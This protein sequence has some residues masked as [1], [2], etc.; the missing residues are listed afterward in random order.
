MRNFLRAIVFFTLLLLPASTHHDVG[1]HL[2]VPVRQGNDQAVGQAG[3]LGS[4]DGLCDRG[5]QFDQ[6]F[7]DVLTQWQCV[8]KARYVGHASL[9]SASWLFWENAVRES[10]IIGAPRIFENATLMHG[11][12]LL[13]ALVISPS[14]AIAAP[15]PFAYDEAPSDG[16]MYAMRYQQAKL[17]CSSLPDDL[18]ADYAKAMRLTAENSSEFEKT[19]TKGLAANPRWRKPATAEE[20]EA[21]CNQAQVALRV[22]VRLARQWFPGGW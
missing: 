9:Q 15:S 2:C 19:Y 14:F 20:Q 12:L 4:V 5:I 3:R 1:L 16:F 7:V 21:E 22:T 13:A 11:R 17:A 10:G 6:Y 8:A 18:E